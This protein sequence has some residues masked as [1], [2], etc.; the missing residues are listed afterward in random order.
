MTQEAAKLKEDRMFAFWISGERYPPLKARQEI[1]LYKKL[2]QI[3]KERNIDPMTLF[4]FLLDAAKAASFGYDNPENK[5]SE[6]AFKKEG[7]MFITTAHK[8]RKIFGNEMVDAKN[9]T[10]EQM[11]FMNHLIFDSN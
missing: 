10:K 9:G 11:V 4:E 8:F 2:Y 1:D 5:E 3:G 6:V 7:K